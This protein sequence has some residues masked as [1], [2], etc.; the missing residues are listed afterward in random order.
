MPAI[1]SVGRTKFGE[2][3]E[4]GPEDLIE[5]AGLKALEGVSLGRKD[6][7]ACYLSD[8]F[9]NLTNKKG[10]EEGFLAE[11]L[12]IHVPME[13]LR[14]FS[15]AL[16][17]AANALK[18]GEYEIVLVGGLEKMTDRYDK[19][20]DD[21]MMLEDPWSYNA[22]GTPEANHELLLREYI[23]RYKIE[24]GDLEKLMKSLAYISVKNHSNALKNENAQFKKKISLEDVLNAREKSS[25]ML[26]LYDY[27]PISDGASALI[28]VSDELAESFN[29]PI[30]LTASASATDFITFPFREDRSGLLAVRLAA[31]KVFNKLKN[32]GI[33]KE[34]LK[35]IETYDQSTVLEL[36][37]LEDLGLMRKGK[38][39]ESIYN[40]LESSWNHYETKYGKFF[41]NTNGGLK[42]DGNPLGATGGA[43]IHEIFLQL[44]GDAGE[45][46]I[47]NLNYALALEL[48][49]FGTKAYVHVFSKEKPR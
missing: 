23:K 36:V 26:G 8:Y 29:R 37:T 42:A 16:T 18:A 45:R 1:V 40:S 28:L 32:L 5:E 41:V 49:G 2:H 9:L 19:I 35:L 3:W 17:N 25:G 12:R 13:R 7:D 44:R 15:S 39:W 4:R 47:P 30:F 6:L 24:G 46:Q 48:E 22:G 20:R 10:L 33:R 31:S 14:S 11:L 27:A 38:G 34:D 21:L 43:Q